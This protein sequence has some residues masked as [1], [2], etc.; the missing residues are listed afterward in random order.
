VEF[1]TLDGED[2]WLSSGVTRLKML[3]AVS[4]FLQK[5]NPPG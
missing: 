2:H 3:Q 4:A 5:N 1:V